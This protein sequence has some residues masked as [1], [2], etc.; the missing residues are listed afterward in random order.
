MQLHL[1]VIKGVKIHIITRHPSEHDEHFC[2]QATEEILKCS[3]LGINV[4]L[5]KGNHHRKLAILDRTTLWEGSL[6]I[7]SQSS[8]KEIMRRIDS[9]HS[10][11]KMYNF[12][13]LTNLML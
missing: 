10:A 6:N 2:Y 12:L 8:S 5:L 13:S 9:Q 11:L 4:I 1:V 3:E 7:L